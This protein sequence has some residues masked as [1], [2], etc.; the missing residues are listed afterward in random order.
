MTKTTTT[1]WP[2]SGWSTTTATGWSTT[3]ATTAN[4]HTAPNATWSFRQH[5]PLQITIDTNSDLTWESVEVKLEPL[6]GTLCRYST[7]YFEPEEDYILIE[8]L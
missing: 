4:S 6:N 5:K 8:D 2:S 7:Y 3:T 1:I